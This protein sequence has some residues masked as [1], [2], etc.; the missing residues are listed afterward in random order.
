VNT[1][2]QLEITQSVQWLNISMVQ[3]HSLHDMQI[4]A[5][6]KVFTAGQ[7]IL[8]KRVSLYINKLEAEYSGL[9]RKK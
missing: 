9:N 1:N 3:G 5:L 8:E 4:L 6:E 2:L 7:R